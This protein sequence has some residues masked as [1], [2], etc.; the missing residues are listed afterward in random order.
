MKKILVL[1]VAVALALALCA[2]AGCE[3]SVGMANPWREVTAEELLQTLGFGFGIPEGAENV[4]YAI[5]EDEG[6][7]EMRFTWYDMDYT[8]R[9]K[10]A[11]EFEDIS[12]LYYD[13]WDYEDDC[14]VGYCEGKVMR[15]HD[16]EGMVDLCLWYD[17]VPGIMYSVSAAGADLDGFDI[18]AAAEALFVPVQ[19]D[20]E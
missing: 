16:D 20:A 6:L 3:A 12:G 9:M 7:A 1:T 11:V 2:A 10:A 19:G 14:T 18:L 13:S 5:I 15:A 4:S 8:A 17:V